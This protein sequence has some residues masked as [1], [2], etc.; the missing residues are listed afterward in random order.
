METEKKRP[1]FFKEANTHFK[2]PGGYSPNGVIPGLVLLIF[3]FGMGYTTL[4]VAGVVLSIFLCKKIGEDEH[5]V[6]S[7]LRHLWVYKGMRFI[8]SSP[9][10]PPSK[11]LIHTR[12]KG[13]MTVQDW[14]KSRRSPEEGANG[15]QTA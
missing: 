5:Y 14:H 9:K 4:V 7:V 13:Q 3:G 8:V 1:R 11:V 12:N 15:T 10:V 2:V 6:K